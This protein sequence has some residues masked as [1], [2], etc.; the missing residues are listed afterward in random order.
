[1][2]AVLW[3]AGAGFLAPRLQA[4][5]S[6]ATQ[7]AL[8]AMKASAALLGQGFLISMLLCSPRSLPERGLHAAWAAAACR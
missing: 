4:F 1:M 5:Q 8:A 7:A 3:V 6:L 2:P